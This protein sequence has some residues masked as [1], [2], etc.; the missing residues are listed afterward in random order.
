MILRFS[1]LRFEGT[2]WFSES[3][4]LSCRLGGGLQLGKRLVP[5][6]QPDIR[7]QKFQAPFT[8]QRGLLKYKSGLFMIEI[9]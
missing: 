5:D 8:A 6:L 9:V 7:E 1:A 4:R 2:S 3:M